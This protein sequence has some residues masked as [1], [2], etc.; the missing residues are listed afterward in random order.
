MVR[1]QQGPLWVTAGERQRLVNRVTGVEATALEQGDDVMGGLLDGQWRQLDW[2]RLAVERSLAIGEEHSHQRGLTAREYIGG[3]VAMVLDHR[4]HQSVE[5]VVCHEQV[6]KLV[7]ADYCQP[8]FG[9]M[10]TQRYVE[11]IEQRGTGFV[12]SYSAGPRR[13]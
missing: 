4:P 8:A 2:S 3:G 13:Y 10:E 5:R 6:L 9:S 12:G 7:Q 11:Q 1:E